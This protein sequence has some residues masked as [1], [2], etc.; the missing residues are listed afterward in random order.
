MPSDGVP[1]PIFVYVG[2]LLWQFFSNS[3][4]QA[5]NSL[6]SNKDIITKVYFPR[7]I[8]PV[9]STVSNCVDFLIASGILVG[10]M[11]YYH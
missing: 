2:L 7:L 4:S 1:Y 5:S 3:L 10:L 8:L 9:S 11:F 6:V